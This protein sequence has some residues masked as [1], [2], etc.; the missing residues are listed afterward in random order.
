MSMTDCRSLQSD[1]KHYRVSLTE[2]KTH[3]VMY[4]CNRIIFGAGYSFM[5]QTLA[6]TLQKSVVTVSKCIR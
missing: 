2:N 1:E 3:N 5:M 4:Y 6:N